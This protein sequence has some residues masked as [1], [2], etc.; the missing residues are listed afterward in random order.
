M[1]P[2]EILILDLYQQHIAN[3]EM[4]LKCVAPVSKKQIICDYDTAI[5]NNYDF[6]C[7]ETGLTFDDLI[8]IIKINK[9]H[10]T[11]E[12]R[13]RKG[14]AV[15]IENE[16]VISALLNELTVQKAA[17]KCGLSQ[18]QIYER[19][20]QKNFK[21]EYHQAKRSILEAVT[22]GLQ[23]RLT[24]ATETAIQIM[25]DKETSPQTRLN[26]CN[27]VFNQCQKLT[28]TIDILDR[29]ETLEKQVDNEH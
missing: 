15:L 12:N 25:Q 10:K 27:L 22:N 3:K 19:M 14:G 13:R 4:T 9:S 24:A 29:I 21:E 6:V 18:R 11:A 7:L 16:V 20:K 1:K 23:A 17:E 2:L 8:S 28:E 26:A 5:K